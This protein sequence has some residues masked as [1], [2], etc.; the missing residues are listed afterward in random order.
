MLKAELPKTSTGKVQKYELREWAKKLPCPA[1]GSS[2]PVQEKKVGGKSRRVK[3][4]ANEPVV[5]A[6]SRL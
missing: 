3:R 5:L 6:R 1:A 4:D 2:S